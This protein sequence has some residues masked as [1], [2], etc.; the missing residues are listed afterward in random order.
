MGA[1]AGGAERVLVDDGEEVC[2]LC[3]KAGVPITVDGRHP[4]DIDPAT[5][6]LRIEQ[7]SQQDLTKRGFSVQVLSRY[8]RQQALAEPHRRESLRK[9]KGKSVAGFKLAGVLL[10]S[11]GAIHSLRDEHGRRA[12]NVLEEP[13]EDSD[14]HATVLLDAALKGG[15]YLKWRREL[16]AA[17][18]TIQDVEVLP[19]KPDLAMSPRARIVERLCSLVKRVMD[20]RK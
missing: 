8:S 2:R 13:T 16:V 17:F 4:D 15:P 19:D 9:Q 18:G 6:M 5:G 1:V 20:I 14:A 12:F 11:V 7:L 10:A 3:F